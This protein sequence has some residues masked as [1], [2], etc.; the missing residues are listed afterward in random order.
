MLWYGDNIADIV[1]HAPYF[2]HL[3]THYYTNN[4]NNNINAILLLVLLST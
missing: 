3:R 2:H 4:Y 1:I